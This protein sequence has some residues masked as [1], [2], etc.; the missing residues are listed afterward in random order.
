MFQLVWPLTNGFKIIFFQSYTEMEGFIHSGNV[1]LKIV[2]EKDINKYI[3][4]D[5]SIGLY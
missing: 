5:V 1:S 4:P 2:F 3:L